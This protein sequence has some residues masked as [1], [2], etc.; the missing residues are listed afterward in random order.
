M[1]QLLGAVGAVGG[2]LALGAV[3]GLALPFTV[4]AP[5]VVF[6]TE[7]W[8][9]HASEQPWLHGLVW[10]ITLALMMS[11]LLVGTAIARLLWRLGL[12]FWVVGASMLASGGLGLFLVLFGGALGLDPDQRGGMGIVAVT[13]GGMGALMVY[14]AVRDGICSRRARIRDSS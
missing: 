3:F 6:I 11:A 2:A 8:G 14:A 7:G 10:G 9:Y 4:G 5:D 13:L 12:L 1:R